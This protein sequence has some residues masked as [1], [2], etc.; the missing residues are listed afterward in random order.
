MQEFLEIILNQCLNILE[1][2]S[3]SILLLDKNNQDIVVRVARGK[4]KTSILGKKNRLGEGISGMVAQQK[5]PLLIEDLRKDEAIK[6]MCREQNYRTH[7]FLSVPLVFS[8]RLL[9]VLNITEKTKGEPFSIKE[10]SYVSAIASCAAG[11]ID[12]MFYNEHLERQLESFKNSTA[13]SKF[14]SA[15]AHELNNP[16]DGVLR[17]LRLAIMQVPEQN[18]LKEYLLEILS[19]VKRMSEI[20]KSMLEFSFAGD[21][22]HSPIARDKVDVNEI[23]QKSI[24]FYKQE[25]FFKN[26]EIKAELAPA[27]PKIKDCGL[28]QVF[29][30]FIKNAIEAI[31]EQGQLSIKSYQEN[32]NI[33][34][35]FIDTGVGLN[36]DLKDKIFEPFFT[37]KTK[38]KGLGLAIVKEVV[39][40]YEGEVKVESLIPKGTKFTL[41]IPIR[42]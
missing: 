19:G 38:G 9:G 21:R 32:D 26:I 17:Y 20:I 39:S 25:A 8:G 7:S 40:C 14:T 34:V 31:L 36:K 6:N 18:V 27:L 41:M 22:N 1:S 37:T 24:T 23:I 3:G 2:D 30:N 15:I 16:L 4:H 13:V 29:N 11:T 33:F 10:L 28:I 12:R 42:R 35:D 5:K